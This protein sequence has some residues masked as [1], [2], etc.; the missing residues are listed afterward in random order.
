MRTFFNIQN[1]VSAPSA[2]LFLS[3]LALA[4]LLMV[5]S[6][7]KESVNST[8]SSKSSLLDTSKYVIGAHG[9]LILKNNFHII[10][11]GYKLAIQNDHIYKVEIASG[12]LVKDFGEYIPYGKV[13]NFQRS[14]ALASPST[15]V[16]SSSEF[17]QPQTSSPVY[18]STSWVAAEEWHN[19]G[20][21]PINYF[22][23]TCVVP[24]MPTIQQN[25][26]YA[27][28]IGLLPL[29]GVYNA[30]NTSIVQ[31]ILN[32]GAA[33]Q[34]TVTNSYQV[35]NYF[36]WQTLVNNQIITHA[37]MTTPT[38]VTPGTSL[39]LIITYSG[40][41]SGSFDYVSN[42]VN[43]AG[44]SITPIMD[45]TINNTYLNGSSSGN[46]SI[47]SVSES[48]F[49]DIVLEDPNLATGI[50]SESEYPNTVSFQRFVSLSNV[51]LSTGNP[52]IYNYPATIG[53][54]N[55]L[56]TPNPDAQLGESAQI[57]SSNNNNTTTPGQIRLWYGP[58][59]APS[60][61]GNPNF[62]STYTSTSGYITGVPGSTVT[63]TAT[64][65]NENGYYGLSCNLGSGY[66]F[67]NGYTSL[68]VSGN[69]VGG[70]RS[71]S[72]TLIMPASGSIPY[73]ASLS[74]Q[75]TGTTGTISVQ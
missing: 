21:N 30:G 39:K 6:C 51:T 26:T 70:S 66:T 47:P 15:S 32:Y 1:P 48:N 20:A 68:S 19:T 58:I 22:S 45:I 37:A 63:V 46:I 44:T 10:E 3:Y 75:H 40:T 7:N 36:F 2:N 34:S 23:T 53:W 24:P 50:S 41:T 61:S 14:A 35:F 28:W 31:P 62:N 73:T 67:T 9:E 69:N 8:I 27:F 59:P 49:A 29:T 16:K 18:A 57:F 11:N 54:Y 52:G 17:F 12:K 4:F 5:Q 60:I 55:P 38:T 64:V 43:A 65:N 33:P 25:Q 56:S 72:Q 13:Q 42:I 71:A 74:Q